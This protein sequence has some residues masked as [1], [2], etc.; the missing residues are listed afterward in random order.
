MKPLFNFLSDLQKLGVHYTIECDKAP[1]FAHGYRTLTMDITVS[2]NE[3][4]EVEFH[5]DGSVDVERFVSTGIQ[6]ADL[7]SLISELRA[8]RGLNTSQAP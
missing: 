2:G 1:E 3:R 8:D 4:W 5:D 7:N 6:H